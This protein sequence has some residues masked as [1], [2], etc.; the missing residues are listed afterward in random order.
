MWITSWAVQEGR[1]RVAILTAFD[2]LNPGYSLTGIVRDQCTMLRK[3]GH[4][5]ALFVRKGFREP[6]AP[7]EADIRPVMPNA[8]LTDYQRAQD[9]SEDHGDTVEE[10]A[11]VLVKEL[12]EFDAV[13]THDLIFTGW[14]LPYALAIRA[15]SPH[16]PRLKWLHWIHSIPSGRKDW[17]D[18]RAYGPNHRL[19][20][21]N[22][23]DALYAAEAYGVG[24]DR[25][26]AIP[27][28]KDIRT[29][30]GF[31]EETRA[32]IDRY[33]GLMSADVVQILPASADRLYY[34]RVD[35]VIR[36]FGAF[37][38]MGLSVCLVVANQWATGKQRKEDVDEYKTIARR[39]GLNDGDVIFT[40]DFG[41]A[42]EAGLPG[43]MIRELF[44][45]SNLFIFPT[46][47]ESFG[48]VIPEA[49]LSGVLQVHNRSLPMQ[50]EVAG[51]TGLY[52]DFGSFCQEM[53]GSRDSRWYRAV[54][55]H[56]LGQM[57]REQS[58]LAKTY[59]RQRYNYD[60]VYRGYYE[61]LLTDPA[62]GSEAA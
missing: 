5:P 17:W 52:W 57:R 1:L 6:D 62:Q 37:K 19:V 61:P 31:G 56:I 27:H 32:F 43:R 53:R 51:N 4:N 45:C 20:F 59:A 21:P 25:V 44:L 2:E 35:D 30:F 14:N 28:I 34:K 16:L 29:W 13:L 22:K 49:A 50:R 23:T 8:P 40:S 26:E 60:A 9:I 41:P 48:L 47:H 58:I 36:F 15:A 12:A 54:A 42:Y 55:A 7:V 33:P 39:Q 24:L 10:T 46:H 11:A 18:L 3:Y 38:Q